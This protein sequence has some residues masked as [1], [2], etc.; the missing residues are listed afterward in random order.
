MPRT[1]SGVSLPLE[2]QWNE[3]VTEPVSGVVVNAV[4]ARKRYPVLL[5]IDLAKVECDCQRRHNDRW[6]GK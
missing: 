1:T 6:R 4:S 5:C 3:L 2:S